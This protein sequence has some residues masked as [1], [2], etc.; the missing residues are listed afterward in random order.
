M[1]DLITVETREG[2]QTVDARELWEKLESKR[3]FANW[4][5]SRLRI[6]VGG[7]LHY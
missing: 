3:Q 4:I 2:I 7:G 5:K 6:F 1:N